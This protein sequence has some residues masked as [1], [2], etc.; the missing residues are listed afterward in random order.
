MFQESWFKGF[1]VEKTITNPNVFGV[2]KINQPT[3]IEDLGYTV[4]GSRGTGS[5]SMKPLTT[6]VPAITEQFVIKNV[7]GDLTSTG[8]KNIISY[9]T[10]NTLGINSI[11]TSLFNNLSTLTF[12]YFS[13][14]SVSGDILYCIMRE[15]YRDVKSNDK[16]QS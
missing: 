12:G 15:G 5:L 1:A 2:I 4:F 16:I 7:V 10:P 3:T 8:V 14:K 11:T 9:Q 6:N 13:S